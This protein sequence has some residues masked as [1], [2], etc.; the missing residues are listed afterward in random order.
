MHLGDDYKSLESLSEI[1]EKLVEELCEKGKAKGDKLSKALNDIGIILHKGT[2]YWSSDEVRLNYELQ[3]LSKCKHTCASE[4]VLNE[5]YEEE[6]KNAHIETDDE[7][8]NE[9]KSTTT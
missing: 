5:F 6:E 7:F 8:V 3:T 9:D 4:E 2:Y 1:D